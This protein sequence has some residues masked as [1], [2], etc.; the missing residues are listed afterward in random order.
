M[1]TATGTVAQPNTYTGVW[2]WST[3]VHPKRIRTLSA[4][5]A[6]PFFLS[7]RVVAL[8]LRAPLASPAF[9]VV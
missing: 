9:F 1:A 5:T 4:L 3:T 7:G 8:M 6:F 2:S